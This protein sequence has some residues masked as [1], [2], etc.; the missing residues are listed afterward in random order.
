METF[1]NEDREILV[2]LYMLSP[3]ELKEAEKM[4]YRNKGMSV[5]ACGKVVQNRRDDNYPKGYM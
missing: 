1:D 2:Q 3:D 4:Y 5:C